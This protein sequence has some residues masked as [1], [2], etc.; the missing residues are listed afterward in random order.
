MVV[1]VHL[2][3]AN[4]PTFSVAV[5]KAPF[6]LRRSGASPAYPR[7]FFSI[8]IFGGIDNCLGSNHSPR[9]AELEDAVA[10]GATGHVMPVRVRTPAR[11]P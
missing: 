10:L 11:G 7:V 3:I 9:V 8:H 1:M 2:A 4:A 6:A 5:V